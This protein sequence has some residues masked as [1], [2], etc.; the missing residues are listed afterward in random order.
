MIHVGVDV[1]FEIL[2]SVLGISVEELKKNNQNVFNTTEE[3]MKEN[4]QEELDEN[5]LT[6]LYLLVIS[7]KI[8]KSKTKEEEKIV[9]QFIYKLN[10]LN[11]KTAKG[12]TLLHLCVNG[13]T[14]VDDFHTTNVCK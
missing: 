11:L 9:C 8:L 10:Q 2:S 7:T 12:S 3:T 4:M 1:D 6:V 5:I 14:P 13:R